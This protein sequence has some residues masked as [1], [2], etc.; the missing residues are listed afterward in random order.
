LL[1]RILFQSSKHY[2][3]SEHIHAD[4]GDE[5]KYWAEVEENAMKEVQEFDK[6]ENS[7]FESGVPGQYDLTGYGAK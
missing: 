3:W 5:E 4:G 7:M 2:A 6:Q 1:R